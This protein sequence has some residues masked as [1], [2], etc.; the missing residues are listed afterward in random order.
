MTNIIS[1]TKKLKHSWMFAA[2][3]GPATHTHT[4]TPHT[5]SHTHSLS[6]AD[7][8]VVGTET[9]DREKRKMRKIQIILLSELRSLVFKVQPVLWFGGR[10]VPKVVTHYWTL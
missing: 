2:A 8:P 5:H 3:R 4:L 6:S 9:C 7:V 10:K 1:P